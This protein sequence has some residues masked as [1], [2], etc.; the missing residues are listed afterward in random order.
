MSFFMWL[1][2]LNSTFGR[3]IHEGWADDESSVDRLATLRAYFPRHALKQAG[4]N[5]PAEF[6]KSF[7]LAVCR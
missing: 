6:S 1:M 7:R 2:H 4:F 5:D 3:S